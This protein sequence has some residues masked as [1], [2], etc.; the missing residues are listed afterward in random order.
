MLHSV[1]GSNNVYFDPPESVKMKYPAI[2]YKRV[3]MDTLNADNR[4][5]IGYDRYEVTYIRKDADS[6]VVDAIL[7]FP[8]CFHDTCF[9]ASDL[10]H[11]VFTL[12]IQ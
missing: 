12:Y 10:Y 7:E 8:Y 11:D 9:K 4:R 1:L 5:Y 6:D 3:K 2:V